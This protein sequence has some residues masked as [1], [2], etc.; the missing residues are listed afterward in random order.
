MLGH[1]PIQLLWVDVSK[2]AYTVL[3]GRI[4]PEDGALPSIENNHL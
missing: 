4:L 1:M 2:S 3:S